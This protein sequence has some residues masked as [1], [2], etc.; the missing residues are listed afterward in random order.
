MTLHIVLRAK[1][2][3]P[4]SLEMS[5]SKHAKSVNTHTPA[6]GAAGK[7]ASFANDPPTAEV[8]ATPKTSVAVM[9]AIDRL[10]AEFAKQRTSLK[11]DVCTPIQDAIK[12]IQIS[13]NS[14][15]TT[16]T[17][18]QKRFAS[19]E[20]VASDNFEQQSLP[21]KHSRASRCWTSAMTLRTAC[22][23]LISVY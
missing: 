3:L 10:S 17:S 9:V 8:S 18:F 1:V 12:P 4:D 13:L 23:D 14:L 22:G 7:L 15:Q 21:S 16:V 20:S 11:E 5:R 19:V 2:S 6:T